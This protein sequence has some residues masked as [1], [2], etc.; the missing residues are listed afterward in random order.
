M[1]WLVYEIA[2]P[3]IL[4]IGSRMPQLEYMT[5][6]GRDSLKADGSKITLIVLFHT[7][8]KH[9]IYQLK[10]FAHHFD[11]FADQI[12]IFLTTEQ[13][14][15]ASKGREDWPNIQHANNTR[16]GVVEK[17]HL[18][19]SFGNPVYPGIFIFNTKGELVYKIFGEVKLGIIKKECDWFWWS[20]TPNER[21]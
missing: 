12:I 21:H 4:P 13:N 7:N 16:W 6:N 11:Q 20:G 14:F 15:F 8:C 5:S 18:K 17:R 1:S 19:E 10:Q 3:E 9:C 2:K